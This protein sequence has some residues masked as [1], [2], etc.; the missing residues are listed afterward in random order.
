MD[1]GP[2]ALLSVEYVRSMG[3]AP[4]INIT[5]VSDRSATQDSMVM[6]MTVVF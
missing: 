1:L 5:T 3:F 2:Y 4:L 6:G